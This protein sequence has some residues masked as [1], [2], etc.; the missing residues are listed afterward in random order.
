MKIFRRTAIFWIPIF[1]IGLLLLLLG[2]RTFSHGLAKHIADIYAGAVSDIVVLGLI[3]PITAL[4]LLWEIID[5]MSASRVLAFRSRENWWKAISQ[6]LIRDCLGITGILL[7]PVSVMAN[8]CIGFIHT[9]GEVSYVILVF[10]TWFL[11]FY[12]VA[13]C[14]A[15][16][17]VT[18][19][20]NIV[21]FCSALLISYI[22][23]VAASLLR[24][25]ELPTIGGLFNL[26]YAFN[27]NEF[28]W[29]L[30]QNICAFLL[31][32]LVLIWHIGKK[33]IQKQDIFWRI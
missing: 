4:L 2:Y 10:L 16:I 17:M 25:L 26:S 15:F 21:A 5:S 11:Y 33:L 28:R 20:R 24:Q 1:L 30:C 13:V 7:L 8:V 18:I 19:H 32:L 6:I 23:N 31:C 3:I 22:P 9:W 29:V 12:F 14:M 27:G